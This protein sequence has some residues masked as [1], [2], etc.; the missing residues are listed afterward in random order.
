MSYTSCRLGGRLVLKLALLVSVSLVG[1]TLTA[2]AT[3]SQAG[4]IPFNQAWQVPSG[5]NEL[6]DYFASPG[7]I[8][9][10]ELWGIN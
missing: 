1:S 2:Q 9:M 8:T 4:N 5:F 6:N 3:G 7:Y 10:L